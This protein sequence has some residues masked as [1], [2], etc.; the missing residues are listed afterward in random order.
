MTNR[1]EMMQGNGLIHF[2]NA[3]VDCTERASSVAL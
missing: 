2:C 1:I 3:E